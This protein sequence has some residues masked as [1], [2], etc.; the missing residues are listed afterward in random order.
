MPPLTE[1]QLLAQYQGGQGASNPQSRPASSPSEAELL[2]QFQNGQPM[3]WLEDA[4]RSAVS[5]VQRGVTSIAGIPQMVGSAEQGAGDWLANKALQA[6]GHAPMTA[7]QQQASHAISA[8]AMRAMSGGLAN[9]DAPSQTHIDTAV[10]HYAGPYHDPQTWEG[11]TAEGFGEMV[12]NAALPGGLLA[13]LARVAIPGAASAAAGEVAHGTPYEGLARALG[14]AG[15]GLLEGGLEGISQAPA[16]VMGNAAPSLTPDVIERATALRQS[17]A[18]QGIDLTI[19]EAVQQV[20]GGATSLGRVQR[21]VESAGRTAPQ[22]KPYFAARPGQVRDAT[23]AFADSIAPGSVGQAP[24]MIGMDAQRAAQG[25]QMDA[26]SVRKAL[27]SP[28]YTA[29]DAQEVDP[30]AM[31]AILDRMR[32][33]IQGDKTGLIGPRL[34]K[35]RQSLIDWDSNPILDQGNLATSRNYWR[36]QID[37]PPTGNDPITKL[38]AG[39]M[40]K[41]LDDL[42]ALLKAN[43]DR[44]AGDAIY[45]GASRNIVD[46]LNAGPVGKIGATDQLGAQTSALYPQN[47]PLG[48]PAET[49]QAISALEAQREGLA[50]ALTRQHVGNTFNQSTRDLTSGPNQYGGA[51]FARNIA[52]NAEQADTL[53]AGFGTLDPSGGMGGRF[54]DLV[55]ALQATGQ[56]ERPGS[57]TAFNTEDLSGLKQPGAVMKLIGGIGDPLEWTKN[58]SNWTGGKLYGRNLDILANM[59]TDPDTAAILQKAAAARGGLPPGSFSA[60]PLLTQQGGGQ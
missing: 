37:L 60:V 32:I 41:H 39:I 4:A 36:H 53:R 21:V 47:P 48:Q 26:N 55:E 10:Q 33:Q 50:A 20:T 25:A 35:M 42:D 56:R 52:G 24:G 2:A 23:M 1:Q 57:M 40:G 59:L 15:G 6:A 38:E 14:G 17:A 19:P 43:P 12:P 8:P 3:G 22:L 11:R 54:D 51:M 45:A 31:D 44:A 18:R 27:S 5:G 13:R 46:P 34:D 29:A 49:A 58:L 30:E 28:A 7:Q 16:R 9:P